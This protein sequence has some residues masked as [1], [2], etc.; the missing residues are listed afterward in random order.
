MVWQS[1]LTS[2]LLTSTLV[3]TDVSHVLDLHSY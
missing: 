3:L 2:T 1:T